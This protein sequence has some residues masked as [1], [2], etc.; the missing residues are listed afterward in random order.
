MARTVNEVPVF[1]VAPLSSTVLLIFY[2]CA[3]YLTPSS[4]SLLVPLSV[5]LFMRER[6]QEVLRKVVR[7]QVNAVTPSD[8]VKVSTANKMM[9]MMV[10]T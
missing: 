1:R 9:M 4:I 2:C 8:V 3:G 5:L 10:H 6:A 7:L